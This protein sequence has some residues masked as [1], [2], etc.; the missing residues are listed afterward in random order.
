MFCRTEIKHNGINL[1]LTHSHAYIF[2]NYI[3][4]IIYKVGMK[5]V[6]TK[7]TYY[8]LICVK[9]SVDI[10]NVVIFRAFTIFFT[11]THFRFC[12]EMNIFYRML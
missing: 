5:I 2:L 4:H 3:N 1:I 10:I 9:E 12:I 6:H 7:Y 11:D 8:I